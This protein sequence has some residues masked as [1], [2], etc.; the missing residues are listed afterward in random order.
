M[1]KRLSIDAVL[2][3][4][5]PFLLLTCSHWE[6][7]HAQ[8]TPI[9]NPQASAYYYFSNLIPF[10]NEA[11]CDLNMDAF[12]GN[13]IEQDKN[14]TS[15]LNLN[16]TE[17]CWGISAGISVWKCHEEDLKQLMKQSGLDTICAGLPFYLSGMNPFYYGGMDKSGCWQ[18]SYALG[19]QMGLRIDDFVD[20]RK[21]FHKAT[22]A[23]KA[24]LSQLKTLYNGDQKKMMMAFIH[25][26]AWVN[27]NHQKNKELFENEWK[28]FDEMVWSMQ[29]MDD[30][31]SFMPYQK[32]LRSMRKIEIEDSLSFEIIA[33][34]IGL[35]KDHIA[36]INPH[37]HRLMALPSA[38]GSVLYLP[39]DAQETFKSKYD[40]MVAEQ[41][42]ANL[43]KQAQWL[44]EK[45]RI[46]KGLPDPKQTKTII[47]RVKSGDVLGLIAQR[48]QLKIQDIKQWNNLYSDRIYIGQELL[49]YVPRSRETKPH[50]KAQ[51]TTVQKLPRP[52]KNSRVIT[53]TIKEGDSLWTIA[54]KY[55]GI[56]ADDLM[57]WNGID[58]RI[59]PGQQLKI[60][61]QN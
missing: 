45:E 32:V 33:Q 21:D 6:P 28:A 44:A 47:Y 34:F 27:Q 3:L 40:L 18:L 22:L 29:V 15:S 37:Y 59:S 19:R 61:S 23:A 12:V 14:Q 41:D 7:L 25:S 38:S 2:F 39:K 58:E 9:Y 1:G 51:E 55:P 36:M 4:L 49:L 31:T 20:E 43:E 54:R 56:S 46:K 8:K 52:K 10:D 50:E 42:K 30:T 17:I 48:H 13:D 24:Y 57:K 60:Y 26:P 11:S 5:I 53:Y 35:S 16:E